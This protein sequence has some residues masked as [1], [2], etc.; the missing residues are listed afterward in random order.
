MEPNYNALRMSELRALEKEG[1]LGGCSMLR[2]DELTFFLRDSVRIETNYNAL[3]L[4]ELR[5]LAREREL[6]DYYRLKKAELIAL[7]S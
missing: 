6:Q 4:V 7:L 5:D 2:K 1:C 3:R